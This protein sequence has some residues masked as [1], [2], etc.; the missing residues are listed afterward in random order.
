MG[1]K[2]SHAFTHIVILH[3]TGKWKWL[4]GCSIHNGILFSLKKRI[5]HL[6]PH[7]WHFFIPFS[8]QISVSFIKSITKYCM[9]FAAV[10][11]IF[12]HFS[13]IQVKLIFMY[14]LYYT[15]LICSY[16]NM[17]ILYKKNSWNKT[18]IN[19]HVHIYIHINHGYN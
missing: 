4:R 7:G 17:K 12:P 19:T 13:Y 14:W 10:E 1:C 9:I 18:I 5:F 3:I 6:F 16:F 15:T 2:D 11:K 8:I